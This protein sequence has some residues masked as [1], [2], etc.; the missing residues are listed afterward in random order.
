MGVQ[1]IF[2]Q[3]DILFS[4]EKSSESI[5]SYIGASISFY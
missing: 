3:F 4:R 5:I 2:S 1:F